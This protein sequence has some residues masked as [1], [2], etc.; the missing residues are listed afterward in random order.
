[1]YLMMDF[2]CLVFVYFVFII[3]K[4]SVFPYLFSTH[5]VNIIYNQIIFFFLYLCVCGGVGVMLG[6]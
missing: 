2:V 3:L 5:P 4:Q 6:N 1:M